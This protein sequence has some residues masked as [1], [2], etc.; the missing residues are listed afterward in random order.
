M[1]DDTLVGSNTPNP[2]PFVMP[3]PADLDVHA[4]EL[5]SA[6]VR[7]NE[8]VRHHAQLLATGRAFLAIAAAALPALGVSASAID[9][10]EAVLKQV[11]I[12]G[13]AQPPLT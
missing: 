12:S 2:P 7:L 4:Y 5:A 3:T 8:A 9:V 1:S 6:R 10:A 11:L 13:E